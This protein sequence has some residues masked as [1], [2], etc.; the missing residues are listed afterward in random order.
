MNTE[1]L[2]VSAGLV[3]FVL[4]VVGSITGRRKGV[5]TTTT[6]RRRTRMIQAEAERRIREEY[7]EGS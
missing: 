4:I 2:V 1:W 7:E 6:N 5:G 3:S